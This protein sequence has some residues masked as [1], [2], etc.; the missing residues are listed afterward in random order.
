MT[1]YSCKENLNKQR[2]KSSLVT[3]DKKG[4]LHNDLNMQLFPKVCKVQA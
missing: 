2:V 3:E 1:T 4:T